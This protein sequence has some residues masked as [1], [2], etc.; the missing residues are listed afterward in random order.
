MSHGIS[1]TTITSENKNY[2]MFGGLSR[3]PRGKTSGYCRW[4]S[5]LLLSFLVMFERFQ[6]FPFLEELQVAIFL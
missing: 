5:K 4:V 3:N 1:H 6:I 2:T